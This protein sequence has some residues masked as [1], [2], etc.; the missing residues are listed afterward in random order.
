MRFGLSTSFCLVLCLA[1]L[2]CRTKSSPPVTPRVVTTIY[3]TP[4][5][6]LPPEPGKVGPSGGRAERDKDGRETGNVI[7]PVSWYINVFIVGYD[8]R[9]WR[10]S[11][12]ACLDSAKTG[13]R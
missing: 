6:N 11:A 3:S 1:C 8:E 5:C 9:V 10:E 12:K 2:A 4:V 13:Q 7:V